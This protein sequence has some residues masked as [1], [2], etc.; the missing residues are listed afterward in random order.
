VAGS[1]GATIQT[2]R[3]AWTKIQLVSFRVEL[4]REPRNNREPLRGTGTRECVVSGK[5]QERQERDRRAS[6][7]IGA[8]AFTYSCCECHAAING[9]FRRL[10]GWSPNFEYQA[11]ARTT[12]Y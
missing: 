11:A 5:E 6:S 7:I 3:G 2:V 1:V 9:H 8:G 10:V 12:D 4:M